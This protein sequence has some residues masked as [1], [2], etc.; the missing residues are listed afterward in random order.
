[1][2]CGELATKRFGKSDAPRVTAVI[3]QFI[4]SGQDNAYSKVAGVARLQAG[5]LG[6]DQPSYGRSAKLNSNAGLRLCGT[7]RG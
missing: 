5:Q 6:L 4:G 2:T 1:M 3:Q 7:V